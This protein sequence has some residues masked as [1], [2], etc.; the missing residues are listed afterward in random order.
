MEKFL[1]KTGAAKFFVKNTSCNNLLNIIK[2]NLRYTYAPPQFFCITKL[3]GSFDST[4]SCGT[5]A[6]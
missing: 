2:T 1:N 3:C 6:L 5:V 4:L